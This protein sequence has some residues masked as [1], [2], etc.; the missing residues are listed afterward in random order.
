M[1]RN[2]LPIDLAEL[3]GQGTQQAWQVE[4]VKVCFQHANALVDLIAVAEENP[5]IEWPAFAG[6]ALATAASVL[7]H[8]VFYRGSDAF[9]KCRDSLAR[10]VDK[11]KALRQQ[12]ACMAQHV[13]SKIPQ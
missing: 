3:E 13:S 6:F 1:Y 4:A 11:V 9:K 7:V 10:V 5:E 12:W 2:F 8:G